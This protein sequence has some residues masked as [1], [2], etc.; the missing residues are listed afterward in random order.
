MKILYQSKKSA[1]R[2]A[3]FETPHGTVETPFFMPIATR[4][5]VKTLDIED[6]ESL[7]PTVVLS[8]TFHLFLRPGLE[9]IKKAKGLH[10]FMGWQGPILTDSGGF[11]IFSLGARKRAGAETEG[12]VRLKDDGVEFRDTVSGAK[13]FFTPEKVIEIQRILGSDITMALD[14]CAHYPISHEGAEDAVRRTTEWAKRCREQRA[15]S[16]GQKKRRPSPSAL[17]PASLLFGIV[18]GSVY[19]NLRIRSAKELSALDFD[20]YAIGGVS[21]GES[22]REKLE[23][24]KWTVPFLPED[25]PRYLM[26]LGMPEEI[27]ASVARGVDMFDCVLPTRNARHGD[28]FVR[29][30]RRNPEKYPKTFYSVMH[31]TGEKYRMDMRPVDEDCACVVCRRYGRAYLRHLFKIGEPLAQRLATL[32]NLEFYLQLMRDLRSA[33][34]NGSF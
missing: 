6:V 19:K 1:A 14:V 3:R 15:K 34:R 12:L 31:I 29:H 10:T 8:N 7:K 9:V 30:R 4:G 26:G 2:I 17:R 22:W 13:Y 32:H 20:G 23:V 27:V 28:L 11:Q 25:K 5:A 18:Q 16:L 21:V 24:I 33:I